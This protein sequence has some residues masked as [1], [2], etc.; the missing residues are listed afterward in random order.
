MADFDLMAKNMADLDDEAVTAAVEEIMAEGGADAA[1]ALD[2]LQEGMQGVGDRFENGEY[3]IG[4][5]LFAAET[6]SNALDILRPALHAGDGT[7]SGRLVIAT[8]KGDLHDIGK[9]IVK[10]MLEAG[11]FEVVDLGID[12]P[13]DKIVETAKAEGIGI[14][15]LSGVLTLALESMKGVVEAFAAA[16]LRGDVKILIGGNPVT[17]E[18]FKVI[19]ADAW[20]RS[21]QKAVGICRE[22]MGIH[23]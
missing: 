15:A 1:R 11:G 5:L 20:S 18:A 17:E 9:N 14:V 7:G 10:G 4:D 22:W 12:V 23:N 2:A 16:G 3:F 21:P 13:A 6:M 8:V 19:G